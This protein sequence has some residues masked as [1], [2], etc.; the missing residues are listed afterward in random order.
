MKKSNIILLSILIVFVIIII[1]LQV[2]V[3]NYVLTISETEYTT[4]SFSKIEVQKGWLV[5]IHKDSVTRIIL[6]NDSLKN[7]IASD[8]DNLILKESKEKSDHQKI[9][10]I[11]NPNTKHFKTFGNS[12]V[13][14]YSNNDDSLFMNLSDESN[15]VIHKEEGNQ[16][17]SESKANTEIQYLYFSA[18]DNSRLNIHNNVVSLNGILKDK[19]YC[20]L[21]GNIIIDKLEKSDRAKINSW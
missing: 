19:S 7:L 4:E 17:K 9:I 18:W 14:Y 21:N 15:I 8:N 1:A 5:E 20:H 16:Q 3:K 6:T 2:K 12:V 10:K 11:Y 13:Y